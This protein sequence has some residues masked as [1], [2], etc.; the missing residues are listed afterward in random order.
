MIIYVY[1]NTWCFP[2]SVLGSVLMLV[3]IIVCRVMRM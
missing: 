2:T 3:D 1:G